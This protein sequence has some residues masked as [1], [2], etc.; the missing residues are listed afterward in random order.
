[1]TTHDRP[2]RPLALGMSL[3]VTLIWASSF[4]LVKVVL[5]YTGPLTIAGLRYFLG[6]ACLLPLLPRRGQR[7][8]ERSWQLWLTLAAIGICAYTVGNGAFFWSLRYLTATTVTFLGAFTPLLVLAAGIIWLREIPLRR[9]AIGVALTL[10]GSFLFFAH[11]LQPGEPFGLLLVTVGLTAFAASSVLTRRIARDRQ[12]GPVMLTAAPLAMGGG[13]LLLIALPL[14]GAPVLPPLGWG[15]VLWLAVV[16]TAV[17]Y[18][19][20]NHALQALDAFELNTILNLSPLV[21]ALLAW[22]TLGERLSPS[23]LTG[24]VIVIAGVM[25]VQGARR[26]RVGSTP[27]PATE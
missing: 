26:P 19:L 8:G 27:P 24:M 9:Q 1:M 23:Q 3:L 16:N 7:R 20:Y 4:I 14:E 5:A 21:T 12:T 22:I 13:L 6:F 18:L 2:S 17:G 10:A 11:G 15:I 25:L